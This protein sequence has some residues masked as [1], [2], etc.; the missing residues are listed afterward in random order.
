MDDL[1]KK[2]RA[3]AT[4]QALRPRRCMHCMVEFHRSQEPQWNRKV[5][6]V[7]VRYS[8]KLDDEKNVIYK[9]TMGGEFVRD[10]DGRKVPELTKH[11][12]IHPYEFCGRACMKIGI[13]T[14]VRDNVL[15]V[16]Q[17]KLVYGS[18]QAIVTSIT[19]EPSEQKKL[20]LIAEHLRA[21]ISELGDVYTTDTL[22]NAVACV[23]YNPRNGFVDYG[24]DE[25][26]TVNIQTNR[27]AKTYVI[28]DIS[29]KIE[30]GHS[31]K[32]HVTFSLSPENKTI[33]HVEEDGFFSQEEKEKIAH[34]WSQ[35]INE[36]E[37]LLMDL[38]DGDKTRRQRCFIDSLKAY[39]HDLMLN[40]GMGVHEWG[41]IAGMGYDE[42]CE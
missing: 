41:N 6:W 28:K 7:E 5:G 33:V 31:P 20:Q 3:T 13:N 29:D 40:H 15:P 4:A 37:N 16:E 22:H 11:E 17:R 34:R 10:D 8:Q 1:T 23:S 9:T 19:G 36:Q 18:E 21:P 35:Y 2:Q 27:R 39:N 26:H 30:S 14:L 42:A 24:D 38:P 25:F 32:R 12:V